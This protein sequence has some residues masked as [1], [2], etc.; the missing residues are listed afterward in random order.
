MTINNFTFD[1][2]LSK[3]IHAD[4]KFDGSA[5][6]NPVEK[7]YI[8][9]KFNSVYGY[10][11]TYSFIDEYSIPLTSVKGQVFTVETLIHE[12]KSGIEN[13]LLRK[14]FVDPYADAD[15]LDAHNRVWVELS[16][17]LG[18]DSSSSDS[19]TVTQETIPGYICYDEYYFAQR[20]KSTACRRL[21]SEYN[22]VIS[23]STFSY[24]FQI[25]RLLD[26]FTN[27]IG[28]IKSSLLFDFG[29]E[30]E[31]ES[32]QKIALRFD[33][34]AK[35]ALHYSRRIANTILSQSGE[36]PYAE[37]DKISKKQAAQ[38]QA[39]FAIKLNA[40][41]EEINNLLDNLQRDLF[42]N[43]NIFYTRYLSNA[44]RMAQKVVD[45]LDLDFNVTN[46]KKDF[47]S[48]TQELV[49]ATFI[50]EGNFTSVHADLVERF[51]SMLAKIDAIMMLIHEKRRYAN[52]ITQLSAKGVS[53]KKIIVQ[54]VDDKFSSFFRSAVV[55]S[56]RNDTFIS[57][58]SSL[59]DLD[60]DSHPQYLLKD[61]G[62]ITGNIS[63]ENN[64]T[65]DGVS[66]STHAHTG[67]DGSAKIS[68]LDI[69]Y[70][71]VRNDENLRDSLAEKPLAISI[72]SFVSDI[73]DGGIPVFDTIINIEISDDALS[74]YQYELIYTEID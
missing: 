29:E 45:P 69:D 67:F 14:I 4:Y 55:H 34:W 21:V 2:T 9:N 33:T 52:Y 13:S 73:L 5:F 7:E 71:S 30:Y 43:S 40:V 53:K 10:Q 59:D 62:T 1:N 51:E 68:I 8:E 38:F 16:Q 18:L 42:D 64:A 3:T 24:F 63:V 15:L 37:V 70:S 72:D 31:T 32:Q 36:I 56:G 61:N 19:E 39:F 58:H 6:S 35:M 49:N 41:D 44:L 46:F 54:V 25:K 74:S 17:N 26:C 47:P 11:Q 48:L 66:L 23:Q 27:E 12:I 65:I 60:K 50:L 20:F 28:N 57:S 22:E